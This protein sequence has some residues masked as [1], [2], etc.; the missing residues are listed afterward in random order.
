M[1][2]SGGTYTFTDPKITIDSVVTTD[3][4]CNTGSTGQ[5]EVYASGGN[6]GVYNFSV[7]GGT[8]FS[9]TNTFSGLNA[10][11]YTVIADDGVCQDTFSVVIN[12][13][14]AL[15]SEA[16]VLGGL[17]GVGISCAGDSTGILYVLA[18]GGTGPYSYD[19]FDSS[20]N[21]INATDEDTVFNIGAGTYFVEVTDNNGCTS[22][23]DVIILEN[24][25]LESFVISDSVSCFGFDN[26]TATVNVSGGVPPYTYQWSNGDDTQ[27]A[28]NLTA[29]TVWVLVQDVY[30]CDLL[31]TAFVEEPFLLEVNAIAN[32]VTCHNYDD[33]DL[34]A[35]PVNGTPPY[36]Y[37]WTYPGY[38]VVGTN[39]TLSGMQPSTHSNYSVMV[40]DSN[41]CI[42]TDSA[43]IY[44]P[45]PLVVSETQ[46]HYQLIVLVWIMVQTQVLLPFRQREKSRYKWKL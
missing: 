21:S 19:W 18:I 1:V 46:T 33:G 3:V 16:Y 4:E 20:M 27:T 34:T 36:S 5:I 2:T 38:G 24:N 6:V 37:E 40:T 42:A 32:D 26:G 28:S 23:D 45:D 15:E 25:P 43:W 10:D 11:S 22:I 17:N 39:Q 41:G 9:P 31:D 30:G 44:E 7:D 14:G 35:V 12:Q 8:S 13:P 29:G